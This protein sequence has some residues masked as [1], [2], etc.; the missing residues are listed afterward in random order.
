[1][2]QQQ[3]KKTYGDRQPQGNTQLPCSEHGKNMC[4][5][6]WSYSLILAG[7]RG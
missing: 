3:Q 2:Q 1:M 6:S 4:I 5:E 7:K